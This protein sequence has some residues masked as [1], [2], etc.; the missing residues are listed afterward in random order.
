MWLCDQ[1]WF[2]ILKKR[3]IFRDMFSIFIGKCLNCGTYINSTC[4]SSL[5]LRE[6]A[7]SKC[8]HAVRTLHMYGT[9]FWSPKCCCCYKRWIDGWKVCRVGC[10]N[11]HCTTISIPA[12]PW[13]WRVM[14]LCYQVC[15]S[16]TEGP[17][18]ESQEESLTNNY[19]CA[20]I[21]TFYDKLGAISKKTQIQLVVSSDNSILEKYVQVAIHRIY[22][23]LGPMHP[24]N[25]VVW[26]CY[27]V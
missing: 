13:K 14:S 17:S 1:K 3:S 4:I 21:V 2:C 16:N 20:H 24:W 26:K 11:Q 22:T 18:A 23:N 7:P 5:V 6:N 12:I 19:N 8:N 10:W 27:F 15:C 9:T 25:K